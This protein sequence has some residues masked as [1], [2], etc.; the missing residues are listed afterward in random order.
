MYV[1]YSFGAQY[2]VN[3]T[4][5]LI[6]NNSNNQAILEINIYLVALIRNLDPRWCCFP[7][8]MSSRPV[9]KPHF[10]LFPP[11]CLSEPLHSLCFEPHPT[12]ILSWPAPS[13]H[14]LLLH[15]PSC[16]QIDARDMWMN[17]HPDFPDQ[18]SVL[19]LIWKHKSCLSICL[20]IGYQILHLKQV[21]AQSVWLPN[22][23]KF[24][25]HILFLRPFFSE[26]TLKF[27]EPSQLASP[28]NQISNSV[29]FSPKSRIITSPLPIF[30]PSTIHHFFICIRK[31]NMSYLN[32]I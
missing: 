5:W 7:V 13:A 27:S 25:S 30:K 8:T 19:S 18:F 26:H 2:L 32:Y 21:T 14:C 16:W 1:I 3:F 9:V 10:L 23:P 6:L 24:Q 17:H 20:V 4:A 29:L 31:L 11:K 22:L 12:P 15:I 28:R